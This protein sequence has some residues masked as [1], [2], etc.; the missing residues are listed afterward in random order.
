MGVIHADLKPANILMSDKNP[1]DCRLADFGQSFVREDAPTRLGVS[2][3]QLTSV[4]RGTP[5]YSAPEMLRL[6]DDNDDENDEE[7]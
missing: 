5:V 2:T 1:S 6:F 4:A 7:G 3:L